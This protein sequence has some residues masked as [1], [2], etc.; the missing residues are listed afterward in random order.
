MSLLTGVGNA[1]GLVDGPDH[2][3]MFLV[4]DRNELAFIGFLELDLQRGLAAVL[5]RDLDGAGMDPR[6]GV[7]GNAGRHPELLG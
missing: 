6:P 3:P 1:V 4:G 5:G 7:P 2:R